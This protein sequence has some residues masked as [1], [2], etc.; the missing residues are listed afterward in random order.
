MEKQEVISRIQ[1][2]FADANIEI[3][4]A[5]CNFKA[6]VVSAQFD[7]LRPVQ[8]QQ[9][10]LACFSDCLAD[11]RLHALSVDALTPSE[12]EARSSNLTQLTL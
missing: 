10:V 2:E 1:T 9:K 11:G 7:G 3:E 5:D 8:R 12:L 4:G 6:R